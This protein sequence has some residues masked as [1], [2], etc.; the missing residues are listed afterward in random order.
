MFI[1]SP[2]QALA[3]ALN[4]CPSTVADGQR[5]VSAADDAR[6][7]Y[8]RAAI[9]MWWTGRCPVLGINCAPTMNICAAQYAAQLVMNIAF[10]A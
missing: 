10:A 3:Y 7:V 9:N 1:N 5:H 4:R 8:I 6:R 2:V